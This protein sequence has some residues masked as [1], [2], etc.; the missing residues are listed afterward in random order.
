MT[1]TETLIYNLEESIRIETE[2][3]TGDMFQDFAA[4][5]I[6]RNMKAELA[7]L[8]DPQDL[9]PPGTVFECIG[10]SG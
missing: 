4:E 10:C 5:K 6:I 9:R 7:I 2:K 1:K 8:K 3:L